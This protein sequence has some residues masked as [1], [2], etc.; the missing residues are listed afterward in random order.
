MAGMGFEDLAELLEPCLAKEFLA[1][2]WGKS[3]RHV[4]GKAGKFTDLLPWSDLNEI[5]MAHRLDYPRLRLMKDGK[6]LPT[7]SYIQHTRGGKG[8]APIPRIKQAEFD[9]QLRN[10]ATLVLDAVDELYTPIRRL[11]SGLERVFH[12]RVQVNCYAGWRISR[13]F[14]LHW[15][16]HD[17]FIVQVAGRKRWSIYGMTTPY[18][19]K[20]SNEPIPAPTNEPIWNEVLQDGDLLYIPRGWWHVAEPMDEPTLHLT[21]GI[22]NRTG[23]DLIRWFGERLAANEALRKDLPRFESNEARIDHMES[24]RRH[25]NEEWKPEILDTYFSELDAK[26]EPRSSFNLPLAPMPD[27]ARWPGD[28]VFRLNT[29]R[30]LNL[31]LKDGDVE[32]A[33]NNKRWRFASDSLFVLRPL[34]EKREC[35]LLE[36]CNVASEK[37][38]EKTVRTFLEELL[39]HGLIV[40]VKRQV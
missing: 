20:G 36:L 24:L 27:V 21:V 10:G 18:P 33:C 16:D 29:P 5:L 28:T 40:I 37:L 35:S 3:Y 6:S 30:P 31:E 39:L 4:H 15:D 22:H 26:A 23:V 17:V 14:D 1:S 13:G 2:S 9:N 25:L 11:A 12:E 32:F 34:T 38:D 8:K 7:S 19:L